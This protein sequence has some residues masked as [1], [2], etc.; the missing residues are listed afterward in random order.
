MDGAQTVLTHP[1]DQTDRKSF[2]FDYSY[3]SFDGFKQDP[4]SGRNVPDP[5]HPRGDSYCDQERLF[6]DL[7]R[8]MLADTFEGYNTTLFSYGQTGS[9]KSYSVIGY[10]PNQGIIPQFCHQ[11]FRIIEEKTY[12]SPTNT[13]Q[14]EVRLSM[15]E[16]YN[17]VVYD[18]LTTLKNGRGL[19]VREHPKKGFYADGLS[20]FQ[21][22]NY[23]DIERLLGQGTLNRTVVATNMNTTSSRSHMIVTIRLV[24]KGTINGGEMTTT[25]VVNIVDLAGSERVRKTGDNGGIAGEGSG[26]VSGE[27]F[28][29]GVSINKSLQSLGNA[30]H[31]LAESSSASSSHFPSNSQKGPRVPYRESVLTKLLMHALGGNSK[32][33][34]L[35][36]ISPADIHYEETLSTLRYADRAKQIRT[37]P[38][39]NKNPTEKIVRDLEGENQRLKAVLTRGNIDPQWLK[40]IVNGRQTN[41][42]AMKEARKK[43]ENEIRAQLSENEREI[44]LIKSPLHKELKHVATDASIES[45]GNNERNGPH[46]QN[47]NMDPLLNG[48][49]IHYLNKGITLIGK[50]QA[51]RS[52]IEMIGPGMKENHAE[53]SVHENNEV[54]L[55]PLTF[56][57]RVLV[58][59]MPIEPQMETVLH[60]NDRLVFGATQMWLFRHPAL[61]TEAG[62]SDSPMINYDFVLHEMASKSGSTIFSSFSDNQDLLQEELSAIL[63][64]VEEANGISAEMNKHVQF[65][66]VLVAPQN[67]IDPGGKTVP[68]QIYI[69]MKNLD[70][71]T[72]YIWS[73]EKFLT[74]FD[75]MKE[76]YRQHQM[77]INGEEDDND[78]L[79]I[80]DERDPFSEPSDA[81]VIIG[82]ARI[83]LQSLAYLVE[84]QEHIPV[85]DLRGSKIGFIKLA[86]IPC[87]DRHGHELQEKDL[88]SSSDQLIGKNLFF[89]FNII[90]CHNLPP[91]FRDIHCKY[92]FYDDKVESKTEMYPYSTNVK[93]NHSRILRFEPATR[94]FVE[95]LN[96]GSVVVEVLGRHIINPDPV[97]QPRPMSNPLN[98]RQLRGVADHKNFTRKGELLVQTP[99]ANSFGGVFETVHGRKQELI[100]E[101]QLL[102]H[103]QIRL[104]QRLD[105]VR[106]MTEHCLLIGQQ[107]IPTTLLDAMLNVNNSEEAR[108]IV[109]QLQAGE[110]GDEWVEWSGTNRQKEHRSSV[111]TIS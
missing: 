58:N 16:I 51:G 104:E 23:S 28:R 57:G 3:W 6:A 9:G 56:D 103:K 90:S 49:W 7:G 33:I 17:E 11:V 77:G 35:A 15:L 2:T 98:T 52:T 45:Q 55:R 81:V 105:F 92:R 21:V 39:I 60:P 79:H 68:N 27:R 67:F 41:P 82:M 22:S 42:Q 50:T 54:T 106:Q 74:R 83:F 96:H 84:L 99:A 46:L 32:T 78:D 75:Y 87:A 19:K 72:D 29:E 13:A 102:K 40:T 30:I 101:L 36:S 71:G 85:A 34:M 65:E 97:N 44:Q 69:K 89:K 95:Y 70:H 86:L 14:F 108:D 31:I 5:K 100:S 93:F 94:E 8:V 80:T 64:S 1:A 18:L 110:D 43:W 48:R 107:S 38:T 76:M 10:G 26:T 25:S 12:I 88:L 59:G 37:R 73:K 63:P 61:E 47:I 111:C 4:V 66:I 24:Q 53:I 91:K 62:V 109:Q 20:D